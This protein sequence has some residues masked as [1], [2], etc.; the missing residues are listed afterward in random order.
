MPDRALHEGLIGTWDVNYEI[1]D[2]GGGVRHFRGQVTYAW[3]ID[4]TALQETWTGNS[5]ARP[6]ELRPY[7]TLIGFEDVAHNRWKEVWIYPAQGMTT[8]V[9]G[10]QVGG[11][12]VLT[13][14]NEKGA[15]ERWTTSD[16][17]RDSF[18]SRFET[19][20]DDGKTWRLVGV[21]QNSRHRL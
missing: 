21:N 14:R 18:T 3:I 15:L 9:S 1:Y 19:S 5:T 17:Q 16:I 4:G 20:E 11:R 7:G 12:I 2:K 6:D 8:V 10:G 13:G